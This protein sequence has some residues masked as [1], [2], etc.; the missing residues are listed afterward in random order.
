M[1]KLAF[2]L[3]LV[4]SSAPAF[5]ADWRLV[6]VVNTR[7]GMTAGFVDLGSVRR[8]GSEAQFWQYT[9]FE[10]PVR[11][12][13]AIRTFFSADC[14]SYTYNEV[15]S[16]SYAGARRLHEATPVPQVKLASPGS[17]VH[18]YIELAC[19]RD[20][21][22]YGS[23]SDPYRYAKTAMQTYRSPAATGGTRA[24]PASG[25]SGSALSPRR[26]PRSN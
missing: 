17:E 9:V 25:R 14:A 12:T 10:K 24:A 11:R 4:T 15:R 18:R 20:R 1:K 13:D 16:I 8:I 3:A 2:A 7:T 26:R 6:S 5:A 22:L 19:G 23:F 21:S